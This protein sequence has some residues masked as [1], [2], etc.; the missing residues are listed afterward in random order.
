MQDFVLASIAVTR[1]TEKLLNRF[2]SA[3]RVAETLAGR[4]R[5]F[6]FPTRKNLWK[7]CTSRR[8]VL[9]WDTTLATD[10]EVQRVPR[11][12]NFLPNSHSPRGLSDGVRQ[13]EFRSPRPRFSLCSCACFLFHV[14]SR[15]SGTTEASG[16]LS[17]DSRTGAARFAVSDRSGRDQLRRS[18]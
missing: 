6:Q 15:R 7:T 11:V 14:R 16:F 18:R 5:E 8:Y 13:I 1:R 2:L 9:I 4:E 3:L 12:L 17:R 10:R